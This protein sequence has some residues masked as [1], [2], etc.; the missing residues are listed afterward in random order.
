MRLAGGGQ[1]E[2]QDL[3]GLSRMNY[4]LSASH[5]V[6][7]PEGGSIVHGELSVSLKDFR[8]RYQPGAPWIFLDTKALTQ[9]LRAH[10]S[11]DTLTAFDRN[12]AV[13]WRGAVEHHGRPRWT[14]IA[15]STL[16]TKR[17][18]LDFHSDH[19]EFHAEVEG[20]GEVDSIRFFDSIADTGF[21]EHNALLK[22][23]YDKGHT[24]AREYSQA[25]PVSFTQVLCPEPNSHSTQVFPAYQ[26]GQVSVNADLEYRGGNL[27]ANPGM[28]CYAV[29]GDT[30]TEWVAFGLG[31]TPGEHLFSEYEYLG[32][33]EF[34]LRLSCWGARRVTK[35]WRTPRI[36]I[37]QGDSAE[38]ALS[39]Y[40]AILRSSG[41]V[42]TPSR[43]RPSWW[44]RPIVCGWGHQCYQADLFRI[45]SSPERKPD[46]AAYMLSTQATYRDFT[47][48]LDDAEL[49]WGT[50]I[51]DARWF[52]SG[53]LKNVDPG[54]W[55]D[56]RGFIRNLHSQ[57]KRVLLWWPPWHPE[58]IPAEQ[59]VRYAGT[60]NTI[61]RNRPSRTDKLGPLVPGGK[62]AIDISLPEVQQRIIGQVR[63][64]LG[65]DGYDADGFKVDH[66][67]NVPG[68]YGM[69]FPS[70][71]GRVFGI[72]AVRMFSDL[73][74]RA[75]KDVKPDAL[76]IG[77]SPNPYLADVQDMLRLG[78]IYS[79]N[80]DSIAAEMRFRARMAK[81]V[82]PTWC[83]DTD[84]WPM[85]SL[86]AFREYVDVQP[87]L[88]VPSLYYATHLD[89]TGEAFTAGDYARIRRVWTHA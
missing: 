1:R 13:E 74:Y 17:Y 82:D 24:S 26:Y 58:G 66:V 62:I 88:G 41:L 3:V 18:H 27:A 9:A 28:L 25:S 51:I 15:K 4:P 65:P 36:I 77:Q 81:I 86:S 49:P 89:T 64:L 53:G 68:M 22:H 44:H 29:T 33:K 69:S 42:A 43:E 83:I 23:F 76:L 56:L 8:V 63:N 55:P 40:V 60:D 34:S 75:A 7:M 50:L 80:R 54:R 78:D 73:I 79:K 70:A 47:E 84:G 72:E 61:P 11:I 52:Q 48:C 21:R 19:L 85:P 14:W 2:L 59:C 12:I 67:A 30:E 35:E 20:D 32:G 39:R 5:P 38:Q 16:W 31:V 87:A 6:F 45:R 46:N 71:S 57:G 37:V 10:I